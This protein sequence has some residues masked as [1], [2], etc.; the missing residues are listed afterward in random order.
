MIE[1]NIGWRIVHPNKIRAFA[2][3]IGLLAKTD[4]L[5]AALIK[6]YAEVMALSA[7]RTGRMDTK[8]QA[9]LKRREQLMVDKL[10]EGNRLDKALDN[11]AKCSA[12]EHIAWIEKAMKEI[13]SQLKEQVEQSKLKETVDLLTSVPGVGDLTALYVLTYLPEIKEANQREVAALAGV[14]PYNRDSG[15]HRGKRF[16]QGGRAPLRHALY[17]SAISSVQHNPDFSRC[18]KRLRAAGKPAKV[19][20]T[21]IM[22]KQLI[23]LSSIMKRG[24]PW[25]PDYTRP[26]V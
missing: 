9:L 18:Y 15:T 5:D 26:V 16:T 19:A 2:K 6:R 24:T 23:L 4:K 21:A 3:S 20:L 13:E 7:K 12:Q 17:M 14:A 11:V 22:R 25:Q 10:R 1:T 8:I